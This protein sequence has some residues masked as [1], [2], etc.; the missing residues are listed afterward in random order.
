M[1]ENRSGSIRID[2]DGNTRLLG[3]ILREVNEEASRAQQELKAVERAL[4][5]DVGN[6]AL[7]SKRLE[8]LG[9]SVQ[10]AE[11]K[12]TILRNAQSQVEEQFRS[13]QIDYEQY[14]DFQR[15]LTATESQLRR[16]STQLNN[17]KAEQEEL[18][19]STKDLNTFFEATGTEVSQFADILGTRLTN[20]IRSG[21]ASTEEINRALKLM[22]RSTLGASANI[23]EM[24]RALRSAGEGASLD[25]IKQDL[26]GIGKRAG[27]A[28]NALNDFAQKQADSLTSNVTSVVTQALDVSSLNTKIDIM[29]DVPEESIAT[30]RDSV[31]TVTTYIGDQEAALEGVRKQW[32]LNKDQSDEANASIIQGAGAIANVYS[33]IDFAELV[34]GVNDV[35]TALGMSNEEALGLIDSL[36]KSGFPPEQLDTIAEYGAQMKEVGFTTNE[37]QAIFEKGID[38]KNFDISSLN[39]GIKTANTNMKSFGQEVPSSLAKLLEGTDVSVKQF[40]AWGQAVAKGG[41]DGASAMGEVSNWLQAIEDDS[42]RNKLAMEIFGTETGQQVN[43]MISVFQGLADAQ[44]KTAENAQGLSETIRQVDADPLVRIGEAGKL[45]KDSLQPVFEVVADFIGKIAEWVSNNANLVAAIIAIATTVSILVGAFATLMPAVGGL[46]TAWPALAS[47]IGMILSPVGLVV[48]AIAGIGIALVAA[49]ENSETFRENVNNVFNQIKDIAVIV[50]EAVASFIGEKIALIKQFWDENGTQI[51]QAVENVFNTIKGVI[52]LVMPAI[53]FVIETVWTAIQNVINGALDIIMG[54]VKIFSGLFTGDFSKMWEGIKQLFSGAI[55][56]IIGWTTLTFFGGIKKIFMDL[57]QAGISLLKGMWDNIA[58]FFSTMGTTVSTTVSNFTVSIINFF[59][60]LAQNVISSVKN[61]WSDSVS[62]FGNLSNSVRE[63]ISSMA[64]TVWQAIKNLATNFINTISAMKTDVTN[65]IIDLTV[66]MI[67]KVKSLPEKFVEIGKNIIEGLIRGISNMTVNAIESITGVVDGVISKAKSLLG[68][69]SPSRVF[70][71][72]GSDTV[73]GMEVGMSGRQKQLNQV[74]TDLTKGLEQISANFRENEKKITEDANKEI[75]AIEKKASDDIAK[76]RQI[77]ASKKRAL[78][79][80]EADSIARIKAQSEQKVT[81]I[82]AKA[83]QDREALQADNDKSRLEAIKKFISDKKSLDQLNILQ[84]IEVWR[85]SVNH[86]K[87]GT[88]EKIEAQKA[89]Q[90]AVQSLNSQLL[91][92]NNEYESK[93]KTIN[94]NLIQGEKRLNDEYTNALNS[95]IGTLKNFKGLFDEF[96]IDSEKKGVQLLLNLETQVSGFKTWQ[97][98][99][100]LL[101]SRNVISQ[102]LLVELQGMGPNAVS[103]LIALNQLTDEQLSRYSTLYEEK[104]KLARTQA[105]QELSGMKLDVQT[106]I[107]DL[108]VAA[109]EEL[110]KLNTEWQEKIR[111]IVQ[112]TDNEL[113]TLSTVGENAGKGLL[114]GLIDTAP[115]IAQK[116][117]EIAESI[118]QT[119]NEALGLD[120]PSSDTKGFG[121]N[122][123]EGVMTGIKKSSLK[124]QHT[125]SAVRGSLSSSTNKSRDNQV[126][127]TQIIQQ[128]AN[129]N[130]ASLVEA[131]T[132]LAG[133]PVQTVVAVDGREVANAVSTHQYSNANLSAL[134]KGVV[135]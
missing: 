4:K 14:R 94:D 13:G 20:A 107:N 30:I 48:A 115:A 126:A 135:L 105:E 95:R 56:F 65:K 16:Y 6:A 79:K 68:I 133:R 64:S 38:L 111:G 106:K 76:I 32:A 84:E 24:R 69:K 98:Q 87:D 53:Q 42:L 59:K 104:S 114:Q 89:Y 47:A 110:T 43:D 81:A 49:Y 15:E 118:K 123:N 26:E 23:D 62:F 37:I 131:I 92:I 28:S 113:I 90:S 19:K 17:L 85:Q 83:I 41:E 54:A 10:A 119:I 67:A 71:A 7:V 78:T 91:A 112:T 88:K 124:L 27:D 122:L 2:V 121:V 3:V 129:I 127:Q 70:A 132:Q 108:R 46:V 109:G 52:D 9:K 33:Q 22:G 73:R 99:F 31:T 11:Q 80:E 125:M 63:I 120:V 77:A 50:F 116:A 103:E 97:E 21:S 35:G 134:T 86:F 58:S 18:E 57:A 96:K 60:G 1:A 55:E 40:Q 100:N 12:L 74:M 34:Q 130:M 5:F 44:D 72:I 45:I 117:S 66:D 25:Q 61:I 101:S 102:G 36:L 8:E 128:S 39:E 75:G 51:M 29:F 82:E 93:A